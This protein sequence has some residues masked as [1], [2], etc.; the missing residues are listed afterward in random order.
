MARARDGRARAPCRPRSAGCSTCWARRP[1]LGPSKGMVGPVTMA[2]DGFP[3]WTCE[4][5][6]VWITATPSQIVLQVHD[7]AVDA[8]P[9]TAASPPVDTTTG[10]SPTWTPGPKVVTDGTVDGAALR[11]AHRKRLKADTSPVVVLQGG[12]ARE[13]GQAL[14]EQVMP[15]RPAAT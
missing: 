13:L 2:A 10:A 15:K 1:E 14:C 7:A 5:R 6:R 3:T 8:A 4:P 11:A 12:S 9:P